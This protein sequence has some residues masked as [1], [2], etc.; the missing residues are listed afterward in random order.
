MSH[1]PGLPHV[2]VLALGACP[3]PGR[4]GEL[5]APVV[6][7]D[8]AL[9]DALRDGDTRA[10]SLAWESLTHAPCSGED[11]VE[12]SG[13]WTAARAV[14]DGWG[15]VP[16]PARRGSSWVPALT[17]AA[18]AAP[19]WR[20]STRLDAG[21]S[22]EGGVD[23]S[24]GL[25]LRFSPRGPTPTLAW[26][27][28]LTRSQARHTVD[29]AVARVGPAD[30]TSLRWR[31]D[32]LARHVGAR[33]DRLLAQARDRRAAPPTSDLRA[34]VLQVLAREEE[35]ALLAAWLGGGARP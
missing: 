23:W 18:S 17:V 4:A 29:D 13:S 10:A 20:A 24:V 30:A 12:L 35:L 33:V 9:L 5:C 1:R 6:G 26:A 32:A 7:P 28:A 2:F 16:D 15:W 11:G 14:L 3:S 8:F 31:I 21:R 34:Q 19:A 25:T 22:V 27:E